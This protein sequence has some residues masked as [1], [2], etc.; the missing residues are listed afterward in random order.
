[1]RCFWSRRMN[2]KPTRN[3]LMRP[4]FSRV[5]DLDIQILPSRE[6]EMHREAIGS[7]GSG[8]EGTEAIAR[9]LT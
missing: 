6:L 2:A 9:R 4:A 1:M 5:A 3:Q 8:M 7:F